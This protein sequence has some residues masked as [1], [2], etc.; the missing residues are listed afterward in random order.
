MKPLIAVTPDEGRSDALPGRPP[1]ARYE[2]KTAYAQA[3]IDAGGLPV[4]VPY[5]TE[6]VE[7]IVALCDGFVV[8]G[9][10]FDVSPEEYGD[11]A[12]AGMGPVKQGR[13]AFERRLIEEVVRAGK[14]LLGVCGGMQLLNVV[15]GGTLIQHIPNEVPNAL[16]H[17]QADDP[18]RP[19]HE[20]TTEPGSLLRR[21]TRMASLAVNTT[22]HQAVAKVGR[23]LVVSG[24][25]SDGVI[26][27]IEADG[28][29]EVFVLGVQW[30]PELLEDDAS[31]RLYQALVEAARR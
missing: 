26:E 27:A 4:V 22:H 30:H 19:A 11:T 10:A 1:L 31:R 17:E 29:G 5:A 18:K 25:A 28:D 3:V 6:S 23:G 9:G 7:Q 16:P 8:T 15:C 13:T 20:V 12:R 2:L 21:I 24:R 14:P